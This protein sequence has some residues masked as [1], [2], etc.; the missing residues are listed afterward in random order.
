MKQE[1]QPLKSEDL[2]IQVPNIQLPKAA[3]PEQ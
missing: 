1:K 2:K 3:D